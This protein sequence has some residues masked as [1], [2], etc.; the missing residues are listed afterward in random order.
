LK[1]KY[2]PNRVELDLKQAIQ[3]NRDL[4]VNSNEAIAENFREFQANKADELIAQLP[5]QPKKQKGWGSWAGPGIS[6]PKVNHALEVKKKIAK[7]E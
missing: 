4:F 5:E 1:E 3:D 7:I 6:E 2:Q